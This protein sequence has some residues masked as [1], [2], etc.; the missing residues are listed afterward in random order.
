MKY[1]LTCDWYTTPADEPSKATRSK[2]AIDHHVETGHTIDSS[3]G[4]VPP[5]LPDLPE[6]VFVRDLL[7]ARS[8][9]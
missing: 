7:P 1:C 2:D 9:D 4:I 6:E 3:N 8:S 5:Q